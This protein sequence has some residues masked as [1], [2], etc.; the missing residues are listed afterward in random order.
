[1]ALLRSPNP[2]QLGYGLA[3]WFSLGLLFEPGNYLDPNAVRANG[4]V[5]LALE[6]RFYLVNKDR[7]AWMASLQ[8]GGSTLRIDE[9]GLTKDQAVYRGR[10]FGLSTG[11]G[12]YFSDHIGLQLQAGT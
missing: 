4:V 7:F 8:L 5:T 6:P 3:K 11:V 10:S 9:Q 2:I 12:F 1:M